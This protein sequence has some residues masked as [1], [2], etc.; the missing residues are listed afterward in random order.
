MEI[1]DIR[2][3]APVEFILA[4]IPFLFLGLHLLVGRFFYKNYRK[5]RTTYAVT[6][7]RVIAVV[8]TKRETTTQAAY[9]NETWEISKS[10]R[11][12]GI[13]TLRFG[14]PGV[15]GRY[16]GNTGLQ[17]ASTLQEGE[18]P[19]FYDIKDAERVADLVNRQRN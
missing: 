16:F 12:D 7:Q 10:I 14:D 9:I 4:G 3:R 19:T 1:L 5:R 17:P 11:R 15:W 8:Q 2:F 13:G 18:A 6:D